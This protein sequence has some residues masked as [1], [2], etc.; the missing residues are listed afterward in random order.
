MVA[1]ATTHWPCSAAPT[2]I[3]RCLLF[4]LG[5]GYDPLAPLAAA[6]RYP[7][8]TRLSPPVV[9]GQRGVGGDGS[10]TV[11]VC[12]LRW[13]AGV[14]RCAARM[15]LRG[16]GLRLRRPDA[17]FRAR[18]TGRRRVAGPSSCTT[19]RPDRAA[20]SRPW[21]VP[22][23][24][25]GR[26]TAH[27]CAGLALGNLLVPRPASSPKVRFDCC[28]IAALLKRVDEGSALC[29]WLARGRAKH[30]RLA[31]A[32]LRICSNGCGDTPRMALAQPHLAGSGERGPLTP[33][34]SFASS[35]QCECRRRGRIRG[36]CW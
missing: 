19:S 26:S 15:P 4:T 22:V 1:T 8:V 16:G 31:A 3:R 27:P 2:T 17:G 18:A 33:H 10:L 36:C 11:G 29:G 20:P 13:R 21:F 7:C 28:V 25:A 9:A 32:W 6:R 34:A 30:E 24:L 35:L 23:L 5:A 14:A 12:H